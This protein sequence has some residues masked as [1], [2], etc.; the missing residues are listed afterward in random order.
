M[1]ALMPAANSVL[2]R[3]S[4][5]G[6]ALCPVSGGNLAP[7]FGAAGSPSVS[8]HGLAH[9]AVMALVLAA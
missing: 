1:G 9:P 2:M 3:G 8:A 5:T 6:Q 7:A 4:L